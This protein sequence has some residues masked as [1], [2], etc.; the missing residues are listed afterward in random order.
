MPNDVITD[1]ERAGGKICEAEPVG[2]GD[3]G[4]SLHLF[5]ELF[6]GQHR[7]RVGCRRLRLLAA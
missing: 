1:C 6:E 5:S 2:G 4:D 3:A 7:R